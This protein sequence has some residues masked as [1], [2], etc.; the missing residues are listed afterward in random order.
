MRGN[1]FEG[2]AVILEGTWKPASPRK[3]TRAKHLP[4]YTVKQLIQLDRVCRCPGPDKK[5]QIAF[6]FIRGCIF[7]G[8]RWAEVASLS[9]DL[10]EEEEGFP[11]IEAVEIGDDYVVIGRAWKRKELK[12]GPPKPGV[13]WTAVITPGLRTVIRECHLANGGSGLLFPDPE[14]PGE[15]LPYEVFRP[16]MLTALERARLKPKSGYLQK[17]LRHSFVHAAKRA[18]V[19]ERW[20]SQHYGHS[21]EEMIRKVYGQRELRRTIAGKGEIREA[22]RFFGFEEFV[23]KSVTA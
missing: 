16:R 5:E 3:T 2:A 9:F 4:H 12:W 20:V 22:E 21:D 7:G 8:W 17:A 18:G 11:E 6:R 15:P 19:P 23:K 13:A 1:C 14:K 10:V